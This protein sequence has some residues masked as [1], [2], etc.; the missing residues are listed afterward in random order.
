MGCRVSEWHVIV[1]GGG[2]G[3]LWVANRGGVVEQ[4]KG[5]CV[6]P[7]VRRFDLLA[8]GRSTLWCPTSQ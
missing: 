7:V 1:K 4:G 3:R 5:V 2:G 6:S 8:P